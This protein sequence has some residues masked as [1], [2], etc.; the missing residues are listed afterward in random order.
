MPNASVGLDLSRARSGKPTLE[1]RPGSKCAAHSALPPIRERN[2]SVRRRPEVLIE[3]SSSTS[4]SFP[5]QLG[6]KRLIIFVS[7]RLHAMH[8]D[9]NEPSKYDITRRVLGADYPDLN[10]GTA[11]SSAA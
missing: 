3:E 9:S 6:I 2:I 8:V 10:G 1:Q 11:A 4:A 7:I 5:V